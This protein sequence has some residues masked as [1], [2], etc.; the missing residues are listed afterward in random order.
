M[1]TTT[2]SCAR[3][4]ASAFA[5]RRR[6]EAF[7]RFLRRH[8]MTAT[9]TQI[10]TT[11]AP[12]SPPTYSGGALGESHIESS[13]KGSARSSAGG[14]GGEVVGVEMEGEGGGARGGGLHGGGGSIGGGGDGGG[15]DGS[16]GSGEGGG[17]G[18][19]SGDGGGGD[20]GGGAGG[21]VGGGDGICGSPAGTAGG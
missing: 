7:A 19:G 4:F 18:D 3:R 8:Q 12:I 21:G 5:T 13:S 14:D 6:A 10:R 1:S 2:S 9:E 16:G 15:G 17:G 11:V 20:G